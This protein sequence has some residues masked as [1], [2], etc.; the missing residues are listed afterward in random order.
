VS[1]ANPHLHGP[2]PADARHVPLK[3][4]AAVASLST[5]LALILIKFFAY[6]LTDSVSMLSAL[7]D[8]AFDAVA[9][10]ATMISIAHAATPADEE[11]RF[12]HGKVEALS[13][14]A[15]AVFILGSA[16]FLLFEALHRFIHPVQ[17]G[18]IGIGV[19]V[20]IASILATGLLVT[21]QKQVVR[22]T[23]SVAISAD[24]MHYKGDLLINLGVLAALGLSHF[25][26]WPYFDPLFALGVSLTLLYS[27]HAIAKESFDILMDRE[28]DEGQRA[29]IVAVVNR[30]PAVRAIHDL[31]TRSTGSRLFIEFH[32]EMDGDMTLSAAHDVTE[33]VEKALFEAFPKAEVLIHQE[34][35]GIDDHRI[36]NVVQGSGAKG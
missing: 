3:R 1:I 6:A 19:G 21:F 4:L 24:H 27:A 23:G 26:P 25:F 8:S 9:S 30:H 2:A 32:M 31:R 15:Q 14:L 13:A 17:V 11:H 35:A 12:G 10:V 29:H 33:E 7:M 34:P 16:G 36:D 22:R 20:S 5:A 28:L 18:A